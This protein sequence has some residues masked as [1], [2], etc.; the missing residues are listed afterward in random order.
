MK[1]RVGQG[2]DV[3]RFAADGDDRALVLGGVTF[4]GERGLLG[5]SDADAVAHAISDAL[6]G[7]AGLG[8]LG[9]HFPDTDAKWKGVASTEILTR[10]VEMVRAA[11]WTIGNVDCNI[12]T[13]SP[14]I[15]PRREEMQEKMTAIVGAPVSIKGRRAEQMGALGRREGLMCLA[16]A[17]VSAP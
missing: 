8:D 13:E 7:A 16:V 11:G 3:H 12:V 5:H 1:I 2:F 10:V 9:M 17:I 6:L 4:A 15:A 14:K